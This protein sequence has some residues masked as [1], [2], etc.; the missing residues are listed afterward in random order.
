MD[1]WGAHDEPW[2]SISYHFLRFLFCTVHPYWMKRICS[3]AFC[4]LLGSLLSC[5]ILWL[6]SAGSKKKAG[7]EEEKIP[8]SRAMF[9]LRVVRLGPQEGSGFQA[10]FGSSKEKHLYP[11]PGVVTKTEFH[12]LKWCHEIWL[13]LNES[14]PTTQMGREDTGKDRMSW[15]KPLISLKHKLTLFPYSVISLGFFWIIFSA[16]SNTFGNIFDFPCY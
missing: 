11:W 15:D 14:Y 1:H 3:T 8:V 5:R 2:N 9:L 13:L 12:D 6:E 16:N 10:R 4:I 7:K